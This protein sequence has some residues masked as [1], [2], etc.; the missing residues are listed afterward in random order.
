MTYLFSYD[1]TDDR[2][3]LR[4]SKCLLRY[5]CVR[6]QKSVFIAPNF[7]LRELGVLRSALGRILRGRVLDTSE[8][9][10]CVPI[11]RDNVTDAVWFGDNTVWQAL[12]KK[13][14]SKIL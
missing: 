3:R 1:I 12:N 13:I 5:G 2:L 14:L 7:T 6:V 8:G 4:V 11:E 10:L 9:L